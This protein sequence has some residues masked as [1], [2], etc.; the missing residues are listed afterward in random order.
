MPLTALATHRDAALLEGGEY[1]LICRDVDHLPAALQLDLEWS[2][3]AIR[4]RRFEGIEMD[5]AVR[6]VCRGFRDRAHHAGRAAAI[7]VGTVCPFRKQGAD[8]HA[9][10][11]AAVIDTDR[12]SEGR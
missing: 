6:S 10:A 12:T 8:I 1:G 4:Y 9:I 11:S 2:P 7:K 3:T 5:S